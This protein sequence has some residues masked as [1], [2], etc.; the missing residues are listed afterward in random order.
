M[1]N[2]QF[3]TKEMFE[4]KVADLCLKNGMSGLPKDE[5][6]QHILLKSMV[7]TFGKVDQISEKE[8]NEKLGAWINKVSLIK[9]LDPVTLR[10]RLVDTGYLVRSNDGSTYQIAETDPYQPGYDPEIDGVDIAEV[11]RLKK[12]EVER[13]KQEFLAKSN[14]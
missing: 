1:N 2:L 4:K 3:V 11:V 6:D 13:R 9:D 10:R 7:I 8:V 5:L 12:E 14:K